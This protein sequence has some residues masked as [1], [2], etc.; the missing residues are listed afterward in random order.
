MK[1]NNI[2]TFVSKDKGFLIGLFFSL[3]THLFLLILLPSKEEKLFGD[4][5]IPIEIIDIKSPIIKGNSV[6]ESQKSIKNNLSN[7]E[8]DFKQISEENLEV[9]IK[10]KKFRDF[11]MA[12]KSNKSKESSLKKALQKSQLDK[13]YKIRGTEKGIKSNK[14]EA[15]SIAG[16]GYEKVTCLNCV[17]PKYPKL[18]IKKGYEG[19]L[20]LEVLILKSGTVKE[21]FIRESTGF[22]ILDKAGI[23]AAFNSKFYPLTKKTKLKIEY[24][25]KLN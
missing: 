24:T 7:L 3:L 1:N 6:I 18:A 8:N 17:E 19:I 25:L 10:D 22:K 4:K 20:K 5:Y 21:V 23:N 13:E 14:T 12:P 9:N 2:L 11:E 16:Q 15:G